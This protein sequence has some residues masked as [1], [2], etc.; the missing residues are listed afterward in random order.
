MAP[1][2]DALVGIDD[3]ENNMKLSSDVETDDDLAIRL[4]ALYREL[5]ETE[6]ANVAGADD[7]RR[8]ELRQLIA[9]REIAL[10]DDS[11]L[12]NLF[13]EYIAA[14][15]YLP[16]R[17]QERRI[18]SEWEGNLQVEFANWQDELATLESPP[19]DKQLIINSVLTKASHLLRRAAEREELLP[20]GENPLQVMRIPEQFSNEQ[21]AQN[22]AARTDLVSAGASTRFYIRSVRNGILAECDVYSAHKIVVLAGSTATKRENKGHPNYESQKERLI[23][24][25]VL[26]DDGQ[27][28]KFAKDHELTSPSAAGAIVLANVVNGRQNLK[29][30][31]GT[32]FAQYFPN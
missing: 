3:P 8:E 17:V 15:P 4:L 13:G 21:D 24:D 29:D 10:N 25:G 5:L 18:F 22:G 6:R 26:V 20:A 14:L 11:E 30:A 2:L 27:Y 19:V 32:P 31:N 12:D 7:E 23:S 28:Y 16:N 9:R 1:P